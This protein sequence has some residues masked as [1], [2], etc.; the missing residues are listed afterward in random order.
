MDARVKPLPI[1]N[2][3][4]RRYYEY[5][6]KHELRMQKC[7]DCGHLRFPP[8]ILCPKC[9]SLRAEWAQLCGRGQVYSYAI[10]R[11]SFHP[12]FQNEIPY[13]VAII[14]LAEGPR[15]ES[16]VTGCSADDI[17]I[18]MPVDAYF[19]DLNETVSVPKFRPAG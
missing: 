19:E 10:Y 15:L 17:R 7:L 9:H 5:A 14:Q 6:H 8:G 2:E 4:N 11:T 1:I 13:V 16:N 3:D 12:A 18:N